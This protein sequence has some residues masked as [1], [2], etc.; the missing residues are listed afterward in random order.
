[1]F[2]I[3]YLISFVI[4]NYDYLVSAVAQP[5][6]EAHVH[7]KKDESLQLSHQLKSRVDTISPA[8]F[9]KYLTRRWSLALT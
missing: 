4:I 9:G 1:M 5:K 6:H 2:L 8:L 3:F 7:Y